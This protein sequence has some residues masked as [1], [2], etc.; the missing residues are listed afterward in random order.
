M[1]AGMMMGSMI[2]MESMMMRNCTR[3]Y[4]RGGPHVL[5]INNNHRGHMGGRHGGVVNVGGNHGH[6]GGATVVGGSGHNNHR[7]GFGAR[8]HRGGHRGGGGGGHRGRRR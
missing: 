1:M 4:R 3:G 5:V 7:G 8:G 2:A 6:R